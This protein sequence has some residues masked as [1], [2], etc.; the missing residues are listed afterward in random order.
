MVKNVEVH[1]TETLGVIAPRLA[2]LKSRPCSLEE[3]Q[4]AL[5]QIIEIFNDSQAEFGKLAD[6]VALKKWQAT[7]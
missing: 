4:A 2:E 3:L 5:V 7:L 6:R 1:G